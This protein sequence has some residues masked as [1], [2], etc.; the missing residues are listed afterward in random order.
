MTPAISS[1]LAPRPRR[2]EWVYAGHRAEHRTGQA[3]FRE[4]NPQVWAPGKHD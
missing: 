2:P 3:A 4:A 1:G